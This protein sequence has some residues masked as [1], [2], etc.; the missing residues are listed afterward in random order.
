[1]PRRLL[2]LCVTL[3]CL[4]G[5]GQRGPLYLPPPTGDQSAPAAS[6][7]PSPLRNPS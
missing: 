2:L 5:C 6:T 1:M 3:C 7:P 4:A